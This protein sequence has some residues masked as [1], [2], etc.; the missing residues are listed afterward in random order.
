M[1]IAITV[2]GMVIMMMVPLLLLIILLVKNRFS[3]D[4]TRTLTAGIAK[5]EKRGSLPLGT[6]YVELRN[7]EN[8]AR[9][10]KMFQNRLVVGR[11]S[12]EAEP[13]GMLYLENEPTIS[14]NQL[15]ITETVDGMVV[16]NLSNV[17]MT[18]LNGMPLRHPALL[19]KGDFLTVGARSYIVAGLVRSA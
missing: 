1:R 16:E 5:I 12:E 6:C 3:D 2:A 15:R 13:I 14:R 4:D 18:R 19:R 11:K 8:G 17:N 10:Y 9:C 7:L